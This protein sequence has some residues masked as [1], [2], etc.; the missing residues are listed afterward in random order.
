MLKDH[1]NFLLLKKRSLSIFF[2]LLFLSACSF[3]QFNPTSKNSNTLTQAYRTAPPDH[4]ISGALENILLSV[5]KVTNYSTYRTYVFKQNSHITINQLKNIQM[6]DVAEAGIVTN[7]VIFGSAL[8]LLCSG[9]QITMLTCAHVVTSP[10]TLVQ[11]DAYTDINDNRYIQSISVKLKQQIYVRDLPGSSK[12]GILAV[13]SKKDI[14]F[15][16]QT[17]DEPIEKTVPSNNNFGISSQLGWGSYLFF[18]GFPSGQLMVTHGI[19]SKAP[20]IEGN[21]MTDAS[22]NEGFS[23][24]IAL[25][26]RENS[27]DFEIVGMV[28]SVSVTSAYVLKPEKGNHE[29]N[30]SPGIPYTGNIYVDQQKEINYGITFVIPI[31]QVKQFYQQ[32][33]QALLNLGYNLDQVFLRTR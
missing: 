15:I 18:T 27:K 28:R 29:F 4:N 17:F 33:R 3:Q 30:Y 6:T 19:V 12:F 16:G 26:M 31:D 25:A 9:R 2:F 10:D 14:A 23:G 11:W 24:G 22:F 5:K 7:E 21:F 20:D 32:N 13:D 1:V 8:V